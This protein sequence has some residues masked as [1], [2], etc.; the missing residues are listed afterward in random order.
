MFALSAVLWMLMLCWL[1][2]DFPR[3]FHLNLC[4]VRLGT[5]SSFAIVLSNPPVSRIHTNIAGGDTKPTN[6]SSAHVFDVIPCVHDSPASL[7]YSTHNRQLRP[8]RDIHRTTLVLTIR[9]VT[10]FH[11]LP[12]HQTV[13]GATEVL[14]GALATEYNTTKKIKYSRITLTNIP[15]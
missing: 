12:E 6:L 5:Y 1:E 15:N 14:L 7:L 11:V 9:E 4:L 10:H 3:E 8:D 2:L 13:G